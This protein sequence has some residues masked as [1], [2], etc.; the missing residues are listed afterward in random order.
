MKLYCDNKLVINIAHNLVQH[1]CFKHVEFD[2]YFIKE[3]LENGIIYT[4][5]VSIGNQLAYL[6]KVF[7]VQFFKGKQANWEFRISIHHLEGECR[8]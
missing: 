4:P 5:F 7:W 3:K 2:V 1:D 6:L 8:K